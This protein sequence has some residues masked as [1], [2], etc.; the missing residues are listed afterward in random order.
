MACESGQS[1][2]PQFGVVNQPGWSIYSSHTSAPLCPFLCVTICSFGWWRETRF[3]LGMYVE[4]F[5]SRQLGLGIYFE[6]PR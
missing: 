4:E 2:M 5:D 6:L 1:L 3:D